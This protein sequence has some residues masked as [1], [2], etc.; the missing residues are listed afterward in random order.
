M[1]KLQTHCVIPFGFRKGKTEN[2]GYQLRAISCLLINDSILGRGGKNNLLL[3]RTVVGGRA[4]N[5][6]WQE[7]CFFSSFL[8][9]SRCA[10]SVLGS[11][12]LRRGSMESCVLQTWGKGLK[13]NKKKGRSKDNL[14]SNIG[15]ISRSRSSYL[16]F[17]IAQNFSGNVGC[18][19]LCFEGKSVN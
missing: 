18:V 11:Q 5:Q 10:T 7:F 6:A 16:S 12:V 19:V 8:C 17:F 13:K 3:L 9:Y 1:I 4:G 15:L 2:F 14:V